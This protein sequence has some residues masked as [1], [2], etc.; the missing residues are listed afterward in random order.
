MASSRDCFIT[1]VY[2]GWN[3]LSFET[4]IN[5][6]VKANLIQNVPISDQVQESFEF[7]GADCLFNLLKFLVLLMI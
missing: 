4:I 3:Y 6:V 7:E 2:D 5:G 1:W